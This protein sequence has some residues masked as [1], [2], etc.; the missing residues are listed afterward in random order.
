MG[1]NGER[2]KKLREEKGIFPSEIAKFLGISRPAYL[3]YESGETK[4]PRRLDK[5]AKFFGVSTDYLLD[6]EN[7]QDVLLSEKQ[8]K[9]LQLFDS[10]NNEGQQALFV[11]LNSLNLTHG[12]K[13]KSSALMNIG[14]PQPVKMIGIAGGRV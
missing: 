4:I 11:V 10:L 2:L 13:E 12:R 1:I 8:A 9:F 7:Q 5:L 3:K 14:T 6:N